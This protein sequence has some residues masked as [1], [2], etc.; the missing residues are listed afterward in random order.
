MVVTNG[1]QSRSVQQPE[2]VARVRARRQR[3]GMKITDLATEA[4]VT[5]DTLSDLE[6]G[7][8]RPHPDTVAKVLGAL[9]RIE[10]EVGL[11][12]ASAPPLP[13]GARYLGDPADQLVE[14]SIEG[15][16]GIRVVVKGPIRDIAEIRRTAAELIAGM[17]TDTEPP[18]T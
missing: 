5:R 12:E 4:G 14:I 11:D 8:T 16:L 18:K 9:D 2:P 10:K 7:N 13:E 6:A 15:N 1:E 3:I 17:Q